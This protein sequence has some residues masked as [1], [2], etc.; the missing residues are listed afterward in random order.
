MFCASTFDYSQRKTTAMAH[1]TTVARG[2][3]L[4]LVRG[5]VIWVA[6]SLVLAALVLAAFLQ[7]VAL[8]ERSEVQA[9]LLA[10]ILRAGAVF[11]VAAFVVASMVRESNDKVTELLLSQAMPRSSYLLGKLTGYAAAAAALALVFALPLCLVVPASR[12]FLWGGSLA[13]ELIIMAAVSTFCVLTLTQFLP[14]FS[15]AAGFYVLA[16][17][18]EAVR[19]MA[20]SPV[21]GP[22]GWTDRVVQTV[23]DGIAIV[24]PSLDRMTLTRWLVESPPSSAEIATLAV[25]AVIYVVLIVAASL[26]DL[27]RKSL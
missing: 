11:V 24:L 26:F 5:R 7:Q 8:T 9:V 20:A 22:P 4:E 15:A 17:T 16:R 3:V 21:G 10:A 12:A 18:V 25:Q 13:C 19:L 23:V 27:Y 2:T 6:A 1:I 14:A